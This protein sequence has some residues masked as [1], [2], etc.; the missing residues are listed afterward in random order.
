MSSG[1]SR[2][3]LRKGYEGIKSK[4]ERDMEFSIKNEKLRKRKLNKKNRKTS[5]KQK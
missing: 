4:Y 5:K 1:E 3:E 2:T